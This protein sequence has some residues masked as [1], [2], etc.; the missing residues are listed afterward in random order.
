AIAAIAR[1]TTAVML[2]YPF[3]PPLLAAAH[4]LAPDGPV[5]VVFANGAFIPLLENW[6]AHAHRAGVRRVLVVALDPAVT[7]HPMRDGCVAVAVPQPGDR[8]ALWQ[9]RLDVFQALA[10]HGIDFIH[11]DIDA[12]WLRDPRAD[13]FADPSLDLVFSQGTYHPEQAFTAW[14]FVLCCGVF[15]VRAGPRA[16]EFL[17]AVH[18]RTPSEIDDQGALN[19]LLLEHGV[20]WD[21]SAAEPYPVPFAGRNFTAYRHLVRSVNTPYGLRFGL[22]PHHLA[23]RVPSAAPGP[24]LKHPSSPP[25]VAGKICVLQACNCWIAA[26]RKRPQA[27]V[28]SYH[29]SGT[30]LFDRVMRQV[31]EQFGLRLVQQYGMAYEIDPAADIVLLPHSLLGF[32]LARD[33][34]GIRLIRDPRDIW[35]S[36][37]LYHRRTQEH[38]CTN[39][40][41]D[42]RPPITYPRVDFSMQHRPERWKRKWLER[43]NGKSYQQNLL[44]RDQAAG[45]EFE[46]QGYTA[47]TL[48]A[49]RAWRQDPAVLDIRLEELAGNFDATMRMVFQHFGFGPEECDAA[50]TLAAREDVARMDDAA[51]AANTHIHSRTL[52]K[53]RTVLSP[54]Q[55]RAFEQRHGDLVRSLGYDLATTADRLGQAQDPAA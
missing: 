44:D 14:N 18:A 15:A 34:R 20:Q 33:Y 16:V 53:W 11:S 22:L 12:V 48:E 39:T 31:A 26:P 29:K 45:L 52:S 49:M 1:S 2:Q 19:R 41:L 55:V 35:V 43:L 54:G 4:D 3:L 36:G 32:R 10:L 42:P 8:A 27:L 23:A 47:C 51:L 5:P 6:I 50:V 7:A 38:W 37:Y 28:F 17:E 24:L 46:L 25:D 40:D 9:V 13:F 21:T 30:T